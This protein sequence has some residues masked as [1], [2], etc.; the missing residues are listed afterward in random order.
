MKFKIL[1]F[2]ISNNYGALLQSLY[3]KTYLTKKLGLK[4]EVSNFIP[5]KLFYRENLKNFL[6]KNPFKIIENYKKIRSIKKWKKINSVD[7]FPNFFER[8]ITE[9]ITIYGSDEIWNY[10]NPFFG[11]KS[12]YFG[13]KNKN[14]KIAY[15]VSI[16]NANV[17][18]MSEEH[19]NEIGT[20]L[21]SFD[22]ITVRD[23]N[24]SRF[25]THLTGEVP[26]IVVDP[27]LL[28]NE[29]EE[30]L[31]KPK[32][33]E[34]KYAFIYGTYFPDNEKKKILNYCQKKNLTI[35]SVG[36]FNNWVD[37][38]IINADPSDFLNYVINSRI[39]FT[40]M[41]H[42][43]IFSTKFKRQFW[44]SMDPYRRNKLT[45]FLD[46]LGLKEQII[47][48]KSDFERLIN[49]ENI[50][51]KLYNWIEKSKKVLRSIS[52]NGSCN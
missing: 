25:V 17:E 3:L 33:I 32:K 48:P 45:Y 2:G 31:I 42:G 50:N 36:Y 41:F 35:L 20:L 47:H 43:V 40:S 38:N 15:A 19:S 24:T 4:V 30:G 28:L 49:Y 12:F 7:Y 8:K 27:T 29:H 23:Q 14:K 9:K 37:K 46:Y 21:K 11:Y 51:T 16:G 5:F 18:N 39:V 10:S 6:K 1:T 34:F 13:S 44:I 52:N 22:L 26:L